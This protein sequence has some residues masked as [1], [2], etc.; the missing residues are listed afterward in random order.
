[1]CYYRGVNA[2]VPSRLQRLVSSDKSQTQMWIDNKRFARGYV[3]EG[4]I[5]QARLI[6]ESTVLCGALIELLA[7]FIALRV[8]VKAAGIRR[9]TSKTFSRSSHKFSVFVAPSGNPQDMPTMASLDC[10][11]LR[12]VVSLGATSEIMVQGCLTRLRGVACWF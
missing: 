1:M 3:E 11:V 6:D 4:H 7:G 10:A 8:N 9:Q 12:A 2:H 5:E